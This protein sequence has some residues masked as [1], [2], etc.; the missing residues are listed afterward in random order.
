MAF[1]R[2]QYAGLQTAPAQLSIGAIIDGETVTRC[3]G[4]EYHLYQGDM[5]LIAP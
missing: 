3:S 2:R 1:Y 4:H 5:V